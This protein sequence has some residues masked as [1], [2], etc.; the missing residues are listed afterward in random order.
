[1]FAVSQVDTKK[2]GRFTESFSHAV[3]ILVTDSGAGLLPAEGDQPETVAKERGSQP[4]DELKRLESALL[5]DA[6]NKAQLATYEWIETQQVALKGD[7][8]ST[9]QNACH[10]GPDG[11]VQ[12]TPIGPP[13]P[14]PVAVYP[15]GQLTARVCKPLS[16]FRFPLCCATVQ[17]SAVASGSMK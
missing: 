14:P 16:R 8:K 9:K 1:M 2:V 11:T 3:G 6:Q 4:R 10:Y 12:K 15:A 7:V 5:Q 13:Q 17:S